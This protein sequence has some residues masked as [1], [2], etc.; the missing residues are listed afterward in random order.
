MAKIPECASCGLCGSRQGLHRHHLDWDHSNNSPSNV[1]VVCQRC[2][3]ELH[4][5][6]YIT[7]EQLAAVRGRVIARDP[8]RFEATETDVP[9]VQITLFKL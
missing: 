9:G 1:I 4:E 5:I 2:H 3:T 8:S 7:R 6:G